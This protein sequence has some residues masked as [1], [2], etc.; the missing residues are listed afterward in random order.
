MRESGKGLFHFF[1]FRLFD[2][3][4]FN[5]T[6]KSKSNVLDRFYEN[7]EENFLVDDR[8]PHRG[9][10]RTTT[11]RTEETTSQG[12][13]KLEALGIGPLPGVTS[14]QRGDTQLHGTLAEK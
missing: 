9:Q 14:G 5:S 2:L 4:R 8:V 1:V 10:D 3:Q 13:D 11:E 6:V 12:I 7:P